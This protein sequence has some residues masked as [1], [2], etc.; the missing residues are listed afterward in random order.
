MYSIGGKMFVQYPLVLGQVRQIMPMLKTITISDIN[1][2]SGI[3]GAIGDKLPQLLAIVLTEEG[4]DIRKKDLEGLAS[5]FEDHVTIDMAMR[6]AADFF[7]CNPIASHL[8]KLSGVMS[9]AMTKT[10]T[11][12]QTATTGLKR[13]ASIL[14]E[15]I[16]QNEMESCGVACR[17]K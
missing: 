15:E 9:A 14:Q 11:E 13:P 10:Q 3:V 5:F 6:I 17:V 4:A 1:D 7:G 8:E 12:A 16:S 2:M